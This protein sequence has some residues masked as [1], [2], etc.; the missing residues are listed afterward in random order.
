MEKRLIDLALEALKARKA[1]IDEEIAVLRSEISTGKSNP[2]KA[3]TGRKKRQKKTAAQR[4]AHS[5]AMRAY[6]ARKKAGKA[7]KKK[8]KSK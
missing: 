7:G 1:V 8:N 3:F 6:W 4:E 5:E 2:A